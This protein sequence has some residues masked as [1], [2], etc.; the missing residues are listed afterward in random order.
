MNRINELL[1]K[2]SRILS[3]YF[4]AGFPNLDDTVD[5][6]VE[7]ERNGVDLIEIGMPFSDPLADGEVIQASSQKALA[8]GMSIDLLFEQLKDIRQ[9]VSIPIILMGYFNPVLRYGVKQ[10]CKRAAELGVDGTIIPDLPLEIYTEKYRNRFIDN[11]LSNVFLVT[12]Q[13]SDARIQELDRHSDSFI[14]M[15]S[16]AS[17]TGAKG[18]NEPFLKEYSERLDGLNLKNPRLIGFG[19]S[20]AASFQMA[21]KYAQGGIIGSAFVRKLGGK[22]NIKEIVRE[23]VEGIRN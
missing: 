20:D 7:L 21:A 16:S 18:L 12:P 15:V 8:N 6:A 13:S 11:G 14:Y 10:F 19:I 17:T 4:T 23:F 9:K 1:N 2:K 5:I 22:G 3:V